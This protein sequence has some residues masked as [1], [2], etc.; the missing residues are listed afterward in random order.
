MGIRY[1]SIIEKDWDS[2]FEILMAIAAIGVWLILMIALTG[3]A[4]HDQNPLLIIFNVW[5]WIITLIALFL[6][7]AKIF[8]YWQKKAKSINADDAEEF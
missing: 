3:L 7:M 1:Y 8:A 5:C 6:I 4:I 2:I